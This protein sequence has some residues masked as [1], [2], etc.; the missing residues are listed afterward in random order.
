[1]P[2][3]IKACFVDA[4]TVIPYPFKRLNSGI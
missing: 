4:M 2:S 3:M 1:M